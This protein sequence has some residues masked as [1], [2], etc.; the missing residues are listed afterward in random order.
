MCPE[1]DCG[2]VAAPGEF[3]HQV[4]MHGIVHVNGPFPQPGG[5]SVSCGMVDLLWEQFRFLRDKPGND[6]TVNRKHCNLDVIVIEHVSGHRFHLPLQIS[7]NIP[8]LLP[9]IQFFC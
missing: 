5:K 9:F 8:L 2:P 4:S 6:R 7:T 3:M 1:R